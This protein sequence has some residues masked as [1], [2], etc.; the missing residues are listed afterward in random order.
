[1]Y[2]MDFSECVSCEQLIYPGEEVDEVSEGL[3]CESCMTSVGTLA[4]VFDLV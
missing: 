4:P 1:M 2:A 3:I